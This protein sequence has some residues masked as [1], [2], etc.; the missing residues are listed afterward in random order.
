[1]INILKP[2]AAWGTRLNNNEFTRATLKLTFYYVVSTAAILLVSS[3]AVLAI[4]APPETE[5]P[6]RFETTQQIEIEHDDWSMYEVREHLSLVI[7]LVDITVLLLVSVL[8]YSF[9]RR[10]LLPIKVL[11]ERQ[12]Q[13]MGDVAHELRTP[14][15]VMQA[16][17]DTVLRK[18]RPVDEYKLFIT[19]VKEES[20]RLTRLSNQLLQL[21]KGEDVKEFLFTSVAVS[22]LT[23]KEIE[24]FLLYA[25]ERGVTL[26]ADV[27]SGITIQTNADALIEIVQNLL[28]NAI[29]YSHQDSA[30]SVRL[31][32]TNGALIITIKDSG[33]GIPKEQQKT[34]FNRFTKVSDARTHD[35][36]GGAGLGL[37]I[38]Q[39][40]VSKLNGSI[41]LESEVNVG[42]IITLTLPKSHS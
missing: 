11:H 39:T 42:T 41:S 32:E 19:D 10:T 25:K 15:A 23:Q 29:D 36:R 20:E 17:A 22:E 27:A 5:L 16:G 8:S 12:Q 31:V 18:D 28:K 33:I 37:A 26:Q 4:F 1:M 38:V 14:L 24:R 21:L 34:I 35:N 9:A 6:F 40:L 13:F 30:V 2:F 3:V 7:F